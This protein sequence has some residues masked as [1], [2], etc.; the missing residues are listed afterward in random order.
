MPIFWLAAYSWVTMPAYVLH[1]DGKVIC[2]IQGEAVTEAAVNMWT[3]LYVFIPAIVLICFNT[4]IIIRLK[5]VNRIHKVLR[6]QH[7]ALSKMGISQLSINSTVTNVD[8]ETQTDVPSNS[9]SFNKSVASSVSS[10]DNSE[11]I[12]LKLGIR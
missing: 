4:A 7:V 9:S 5:R 1:A 11:K 2:S 12:S 10:T 6:S 3:S 8:N